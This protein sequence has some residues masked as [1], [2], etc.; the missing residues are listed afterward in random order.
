MTNHYD[1]LWAILIISFIIITLIIIEEIK[2]GWILARLIKWPHYCF[3]FGNHTGFLY[4]YIWYLDK[5]NNYTRENRW[6]VKTK[7]Y[8]NI[9]I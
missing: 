8:K 3:G 1:I 4:I 7:L 5:C 2:Y 6:K 9:Y